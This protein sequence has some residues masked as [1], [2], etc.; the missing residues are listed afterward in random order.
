MFAV[1]REATYDPEKRAGGGGQLEEFARLRARQPGYRGTVT[2]DTGN[3]RTLSLA[4]W[5]T[6]QQ[7]QAASATLRPEAERLLGPL[8]TDPSQWIASGPV[9][10]DDIP[11]A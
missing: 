7:A 8:W 4:L 9:L 6:E 2:V 3:G 5:E 1:V 11:K 10:Q